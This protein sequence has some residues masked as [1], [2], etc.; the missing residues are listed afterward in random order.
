VTFAPKT[1]V[2]F[3]KS[4]KTQKPRFE[5]VFRRV[6]FGGFF[7]C[8]PWCEEGYVFRLTGASE[9]YEKFVVVSEWHHILIGESFFIGFSCQSLIKDS[10]T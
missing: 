9:R 2:S 10:A 8:Q 3:K 1:N 4:N 7:Y 5:V 6:F